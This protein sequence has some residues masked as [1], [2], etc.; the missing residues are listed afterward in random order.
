M[1][2][3]LLIADA[4][5]YTAEWL[6][7]CINHDVAVRVV[8]S[9]SSAQQALT[10]DREAAIVIGQHLEDGQGIELIHTLSSRWRATGTIPPIF[11]INHAS[12]HTETANGVY[13]ALHHAMS[14]DDVRSLILRAIYGIEASPSHS[15]ATMQSVAQA[16]QMQQ[17][18]D[19]AHPLAQMRDLAS[20]AEHCLAVIQELTD[21]QRAYCWFHDAESG[22]LWSETHTPSAHRD[23]HHAICGLTGLSART[24]RSICVARA[25]SHACYDAG[26]DDPDGSGD[27]PLLAQPVVGSDG[28]VH[29]VF[30]AVR[31]AGQ[32]TFSTAEQERL[33]AFARQASPLLEQLGLHLE[34]EAIL[35]TTRV[36][37]VF[38]QDAL[39][40]HTSHN[41][42]GDVVRVSPRWSDWAYW[43]IVAFV[44]AALGYAAVTYISRYS[45][46]PAVVRVA[47]RSAIT[48]HLDATVGEVHVTPGQHVKR[49]EALLSFYDTTQRAMVELLQKEFDTQLRNRLLDPSNQTAKQAVS[50]LRT[51]LERARA[52]LEER[53]V[54]APRDGVVNDIRVRSGQRATPGD[55]LMSLLHDDSD[56]YIE[57]LLPGADRPQLSPG[58]PL[59]LE[60]TG[61]PY[62]YQML[63]IDTVSTEVVGPNEAHRFLGPQIGD[64][65]PINGPVVLVKARLP[66]RK[67]RADGQT[68]H[69][70]DGMQAKA[71]V[72]LRSRHLLKM[73]VPGMEKP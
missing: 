44:I 56:L 63:A 6:A 10:E 51:D 17:L 46:G 21:C 9:I 37:G 45:Y 52:T 53:T 49:G 3:E 70:Y 69:Y 66:G 72:Q 40:A 59:R 67:F 19:M 25:A 18:L 5:R 55:A 73:L 14:R 34:A 38:R 20:A 58:M 71:E 4:D 29:A 32:A 68:Y 28:Q 54:R 26:L 11:T 60:I 41:P 43:V 65:I 64:A 35:Q 57:A 23:D 27:D 62:A 22:L 15:R 7:D 42:Y 36:P 30:V 2:P 16:R 12:C 13:Y 31:P 39:D 1:M 48:A 24:G 33:Y 61:Y 50:T 47:N 8:T